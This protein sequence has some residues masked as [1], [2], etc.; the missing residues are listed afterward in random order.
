MGLKDEVD[1]LRRV[2]LFAQMDPAKLKL[3]AFTSQ[4]MTFQP[5]QS[6]FKQGD[7]GD[8]AYV[9]MDGEAEVIAET[10]QGAIPVAKIGKNAIIGEIAILCDVPRTATVKASTSL[11]TL[12]IDKEDFLRLIREFPD[13]GIEIMRELADRLSRTTTELSECRSKLKKI[14]N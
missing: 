9:L 4:R 11:A 2:P 10:P 12:K 5:E 6:L 7:S 3:L 13:M 14:T 1:L 8:A